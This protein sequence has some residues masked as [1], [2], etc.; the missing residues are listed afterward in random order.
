MRDCVTRGQ[1]SENDQFDRITRVEGRVNDALPVVMRDGSADSIHPVVLSEFF[2]P[3]LRRFQFVS[4][5]PSQIQ[6]VYA[7]DEDRDAA[8][9]REFLRILAMKNA[10]PSILTKV[11]RVADLPP[12]PVTGKHRLVLMPSR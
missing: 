4:Q 9:Q 11:E 10:D 7:A 6:V 3:G 12:D 1:R 8:V 5:S 2:V